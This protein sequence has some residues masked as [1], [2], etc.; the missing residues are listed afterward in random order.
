M[1]EVNTGGGKKSSPR[2][3]MTPMVD[4]GFLLVTFFMVTTTFS[5]PMVMELG[6]PDKNNPTK[7]NMKIKESRAITLILG[8]ENRV[9]YYTGTGQDAENTHIEVGYFNDGKK[10]IRQALLRRK[11]EVETNPNLSAKEKSDG[12]VVLIKPD[13][14]S[15]Y[16]NVVD[17]LDEMKICDIHIYAIVDIS[18]PE[19]DM[20]Q[21]VAV[22]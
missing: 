22:E 12:M 3:D 7:D 19:K 6:M 20:I 16:K 10:S 18:K 8:K 4:L 5:K 1:A 21:S 2:V 13:E 11:Q 15:N 17:I 9:F 14:E